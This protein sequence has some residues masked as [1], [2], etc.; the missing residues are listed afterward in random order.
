MMK[1]LLIASSLA[2]FA[3]TACHTMAQTPVPAQP[4]SFI[5]IGD[6]PYG[7]ADFPV[8][9][10]AVEKISGG[11]FPFVIHVGDYKG[12]GA[13]CLPEHDDYHAGLIKRLAP[14]PVFY[15]PGDNE[16]TD[17]DRFKHADTGENYSDLDRL[18]IVRSRF[19]GGNAPTNFGAVHQDGMPE[20]ARWS[21]DGAVFATLH[22]T[23]TNNG[24]NWVT[25]DPLPRAKAAVEAR[26]K[27][28]TLWITETLKQ[29]QSSDAR[30]IVIAM[31]SD[32]TDIKEKYDVITLFGGAH[33]TFFQDFIREDG[34][35]YLIRGEGEESM[36]EILEAI[37]KKE[38]F[39]RVPNLSYIDNEGKTKHNPLR[40]LA[41][42]MD[43]YPY[44]DRKLY[45]ALDKNQERQVR[46]VITSRGCPF[47]CSF[48]FEDATS[49]FNRTFI[50]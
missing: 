37:D 23:G 12:G 42:D 8:L 19:F 34:V 35:D 13:E 43:E 30:A 29:A 1:P 44:P 18:D 24:R 14:T 11:D 25:G 20:N 49:I 41:K 50:L 36:V 4:I 47:H 7:E 17:C 26:D 9:D 33:P 21:H 46:N 3:L 32:M 10:Q 22:V 28:N 16:W 2:A 31:Q 48:C 5:V 45:H 6:T 39:D 40:N 27:A 38:S 15:T